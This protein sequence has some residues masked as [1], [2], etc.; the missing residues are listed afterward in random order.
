MRRESKIWFP[1]INPFPPK[2][3]S[4]GFTVLLSGK[5]VY[6]TMELVYVALAF[7]IP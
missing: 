6:R 1:I 3:Y 5:T 2:L 7:T 4:P